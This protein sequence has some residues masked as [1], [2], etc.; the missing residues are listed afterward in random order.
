MKRDMDLVRKILKKI[1]D[2]EDPYGLNGIPE[3]EGYSNSEISYHVDILSDAGLLTSEPLGELGVDYNDFFHI[4][5]TWYGQDFIDAA[6]D[7]TIWEKAKKT[8]LKP[9]VSFTFDIL[10]EWLKSEIKE[11]IGMV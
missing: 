10:K 9:G 8:V 2:H 11:K 7:E 5:L 3:I 6:E 1:R 4:N